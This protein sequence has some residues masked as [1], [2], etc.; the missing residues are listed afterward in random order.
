[1]KH[2]SDQDYR[3][4]L[5]DIKAKNAEK[6]RKRKLKAER[7]KARA[8]HLPETHK[9]F[10]MYLFVL[11]NAILVYALVAMWVFADLQ[12][13]GVLITDI[14]AQVLVY[15]I[16][17]LKAYNGKKQ[18]EKIKLEREKAGLSDILQAGAEST[19]PVNLNNGPLDTSYP[20]GGG[21][22]LQDYYEDTSVCANI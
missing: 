20:T 6:E 3:R 18:E 16:Y 14:A 17:C 4:E 11:F 10:A 22:V 15:G 13:L 1:M 19:E 9:V 12:W 21:A 5:Y 7:K 2:L 8:W